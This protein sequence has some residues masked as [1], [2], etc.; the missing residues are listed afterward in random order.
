MLNSVNPDEIRLTTVPSLDGVQG[1]ANSKHF[2]AKIFFLCSFLVFREAYAVIP[3]SAESVN[4]MTQ[5][6]GMS[7][8]QL[9]TDRN[10]ALQPSESIDPLAESSPSA[11]TEDSSQSMQ[12]KAFD[13]KSV[14]FHFRIPDMISLVILNRNRDIYRWDWHYRHYRHVPNGNSIGKSYPSYK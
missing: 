12:E 11:I 14:L 10:L 7:L 9:L 2:T 3:L 8:E 1:N 5:R 4:R 6:S 13:G